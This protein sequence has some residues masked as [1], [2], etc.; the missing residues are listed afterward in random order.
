MNYKK[1]DK[2]KVLSSMF[3]AINSGEVYTLSKAN[4]S[5]VFIKKEGVHWCFH[6]NEVELIK[7]PNDIKPE[8]YKT[9]KID[10]IDFC[11]LYNLNFNLGNVVKYVSR[12]GKKESELTDL[13]KAKEYICREIE[14]LQT[15]NK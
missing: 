1:G 6:L 4:Q 11:K 8:H 2:V 13:L 15:K 5:G 9:D 3:C 10:V 7:E 14:F 12:A